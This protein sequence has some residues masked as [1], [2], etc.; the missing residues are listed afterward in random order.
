MTYAEFLA[1]SRSVGCQEFLGADHFATF[2]TFD[3]N[4]DGL[5]C[6][7]D[8]PDTPGH[9]GAWVFNA[10]TTRRTRDREAWA[11]SAHVAARRL[12][13]DRTLGVHWT[14]ARRERA[15]VLFG[16]G[17]LSAPQGA[18]ASPRHLDRTR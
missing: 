14:P 5:V 17:G 8:L 18:R 6:I 10:L 15:L 2:Q 4:N 11:P 1:L 13:P 3:K 9:L 16:P 12:G 7:K